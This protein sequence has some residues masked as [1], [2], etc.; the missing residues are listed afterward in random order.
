M[1]RSILAALVLLPTAALAQ[2]VQLTTE[3]VTDELNSPVFLT[4]P[5]GDPRLFVV[6]QSGQVRIIAHGALVRQPF[7]DIIDRTDPGGEQGLLGLAFHPDYAGNG[8]FFINYTDRN[9][10]TQIE[11]CTVSSDPALA[12]PASCATVLSVPQPY[13]NH[14]GGWIAFGPDG[15]LYIGMGDGGAG[16]D[17]ENRAQNPDELL[18]KILRIDVDGAAPYAIPPENPFAS[19]G[20][21]PEIFVL[22]VRN[23]WRNAFDGTDL[24]VA[25]VGQGAFEE[26]TV[27]STADAGVNLGWRPME[28]QAC[29]ERGCDPTGFVLPQHTYSHTDGCSISGGYVY[30]GAAIP[31]IAG[32]YFF[33]DFCSEKVWSFRFADGA[34]ADYTAWSEDLGG[35]G[36]IS[37]F[38]LDSAGELYI[39]TLNGRLFK[40]VK[41]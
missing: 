12:D 26:V 24:Y 19:R 38:G 15:Y 17:P 30:R 3:L 1:L 18:G 9:G 40:V 8:R 35:K 37:S 32:H 28:G 34:A 22:G 33:A 27:I 16:G 14:N 36:P 39:T 4:A 5:A 7:L 20:G 11:G 25:D 23:P 13:G 31:E 29:Y 21:A 41:Q 10:D 6:Q 2:P